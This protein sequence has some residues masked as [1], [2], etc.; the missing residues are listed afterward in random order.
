MKKKNIFTRIA[1]WSFLLS[2]MFVS[3]TQDEFF[4]EGCMYSTNASRF[5]GAG[6]EMTHTVSKAGT[7]TSEQLQVGSLPIKE[8]YGTMT[9]SWP[10]GVPFS[11]IDSQIQAEANVEIVAEDKYRCL[12][13]TKSLPSSHNWVASATCTARIERINKDGSKDTVYASFSHS[14]QIETTEAPI[15][16]SNN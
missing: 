15:L 12:S 9:L 13:T 7:S 6:I 4:D 2:P 8:I 3:C 14:A 1:I 10:G 16:N 11:S 5:S